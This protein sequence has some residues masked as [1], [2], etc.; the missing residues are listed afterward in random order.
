MLKNHGRD[1]LSLKKKKRRRRRSV[2]SVRV[3]PT[4]NSTAASDSLVD[5]AA[6]P[7]SIG[8][9]AHCATHLRRNSYHNLEL[10]PSKPF[11]QKYLKIILK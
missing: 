4:D 7:V 2:D 8:R 1:L 11:L 10:T 6:V 3:F 5:T 9:E